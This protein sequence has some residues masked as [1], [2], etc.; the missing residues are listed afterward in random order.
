MNIKSSSLSTLFFC[1][2]FLGGSGAFA[3]DFEVRPFAASYY[4]ENDGRQ[5]GQGNNGSDPNIT[6]ALIATETSPRASIN[7]SWDDLHGIDS[8]NFNGVWE[9]DIEV[10]DPVATINANF[11]LSWSDVSFYLNGE[12]Q[13][14]WANS[15]KHLPLTLPQ[16]VHRVR[17]EHHNHWHTTFFNVSF[18]DYPKLTTSKLVEYDELAALVDDDTRIVYVAG[19]EANN[20]FNEATITLPE[21]EGSIILFVSSYSPV[22]WII[23]NPNNTDIAAVVF[24]SY[25]QGSTIE[26]EAGAAVYDVA[27]FNWRYNNTSAGQ[28]QISQLTGAS[29]DYTYSS[30]NLSRI[31]VPDFQ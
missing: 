9:G 6:P 16:G 28:A 27:D 25:S 24:T 12:L 30:Y 26:N 7:Y 15:D 2:V 3:A 22:N 11:S 13:H 23:D 17:I 1:G 4:L 5:P 29:T 31:T 19:Y 21:H 18:T 20:R 14:R 10:F 8:Y